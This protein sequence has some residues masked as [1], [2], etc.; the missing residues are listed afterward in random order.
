MERFKYDC[1]YYPCHFK[2]QDC[3]FCYC[4]IYPCGY[5][6]MGGIWITNDVW[7]CSG[8]SFIHE[9]SIAKLLKRAFRIYFKEVAK[10]WH[11]RSEKETGQ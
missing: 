9:A 2:E 11:K 6:E 5:E 8:C 10:L 7:D 1:E 3:T 4:P